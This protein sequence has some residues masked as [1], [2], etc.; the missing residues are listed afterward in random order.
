MLSRSKSSHPSVIEK[1]FL[2]AL[3]RLVACKPTNTALKKLAAQGRLRINVSTV[4]KEAGRA[5]SLIGYE[6][7]KYMGVRLQVLE[8][9]KPIASPR[10]GAAVIA[11]LREDVA[12]LKLQLHNALAEAAAHFHA[13][14]KAERDAERWRHAYDRLT[15]STSSNDATI[16]DFKR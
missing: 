3:E 13:R 16:T 8:Q 10:S 7:C 2:T 11:R 6:G 1:D 4:A 12:D 9:M 15:K 5:R 14:H